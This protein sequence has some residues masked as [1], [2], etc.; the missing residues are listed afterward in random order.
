[1][2][3]EKTFKQDKH[4]TEILIMPSDCQEKNGESYM[5]NSHPADQ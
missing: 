5:S 1:M 4:V 2:Q 3:D